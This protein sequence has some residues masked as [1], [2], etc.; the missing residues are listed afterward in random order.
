[1]EVQTA[2]QPRLFFDL[3]VRHGVPGTEEGLRAAAQT[4]GFV[5]NS[6]ELD[7]KRRY[8]EGVTPWRAL[9]VAVETFGRLGRAGLADLRELARAET[10]K[11]GGDAVWTTHAFLQRWCARLSV[12]LH[13]ANARALLTAGASESGLAWAEQ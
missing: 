2:G 12:A 13:R 5:N 10:A 3:T 1:M 8:P 6:A 7:K 9:P 4:A 11:V